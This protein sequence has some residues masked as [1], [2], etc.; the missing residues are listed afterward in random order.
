MNNTQKLIMAQRE[1]IKLCNK[2]IG[3][4]EQSSIE[5]TELRRK[6]AKLEAKIIEEESI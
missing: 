5:L 1:Y 6:I 3:N 4:W 2:I